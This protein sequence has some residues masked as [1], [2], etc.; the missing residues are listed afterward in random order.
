MLV[1]EMRARWQ[2]FACFFRPGFI[3]GPAG[4]RLCFWVLGSWLNILGGLF[5]ALINDDGD[6]AWPGT[7]AFS[8]NC[9]D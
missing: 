7:L 6:L 1:I 8:V 2:L 5:G 9:N 4:W 3:Y